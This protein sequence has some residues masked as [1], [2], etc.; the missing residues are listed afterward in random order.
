M[1]FVSSK[2]WTDVFCDGG[3]CERKFIWQKGQRERVPRGWTKV[4][5]R[6]GSCVEYY[7]SAHRACAP[8]AQPECTKHPDRRAEPSST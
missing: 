2:G 5:R 6:C 4:E 3:Q 8:Q 7:C 1:F